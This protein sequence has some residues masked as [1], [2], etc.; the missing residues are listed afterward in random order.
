M[1]APKDRK[2]EPA[3]TADW[4]SFKVAMLTD[5]A[6][7]RASNLSKD[8]LSVTRLETFFSVQGETLAVAVQLWAAMMKDMPTAGVPTTTNVAKWN[9]IAQ[10]TH[11][12]ITF[13]EEGFLEEL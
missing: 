1:P 10:Q 6:Y 4:G 9:A 7:Q 5:A 13:N 11:M 12:P 3:N 2:L 8:P